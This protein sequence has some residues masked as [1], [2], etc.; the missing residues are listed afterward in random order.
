MRI[1]DG[2]RR[3]NFV[4]TLERRA[5]TDFADVESVVR[6]IVEDV[7]KNGDRSLRLYAARWDG[8]GKKEPLRVPEAE[9]QEAW[10][11]TPPQ[12]QSAIR[13]AAA[14][15][16][17]Y[18]EWQKPQEWQREIQPGVCVGQL[19]RPLESV[20]CY[21]PGGRYPLPST[22]LM[23]VIPAQVAGVRQIRVVSPKAAPVTLAVAGFLSV[24]EFYR[25]GG[26]QAIAALAYG[27]ESVAPVT[28]IVGPGNRFVTAAK[29]RVAFDCA[30]EFLAGPTEAVVISEDGDPSCIASDLVAQAE[31]DPDALCVFITPVCSLAKSV[32]SEVKIRTRNNS[33]ARQSLTRR[34]A[35]LL[36]ASL[37]E[38]IETASRIAPEHLTVPAAL[39][40]AVRNAGSVFLDEFSP[41]AAGDYI[42]GPNHVLPTGGMARV[43]GGLSVLDFVQIIACQNVSKE[44][45]QHIAPA[46]IA[47]AEA[48][49]LRGHAESLRVRCSHA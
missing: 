14:N 13:Q 11:Q 19:V 15:I 17:R 10:H 31:H 25:V 26:A 30:I 21:V 37:D 1:L 40:P 16:R 45:I 22:L 38:A 49:G 48:E 6:R 41:Q 2:P 9:L 34:G 32:Q 43:R 29:K 42:S 46:A 35:I 5:T 18:C 7:R 24:S 8:L 44:G 3:H 4:R 27:T 12:L 39:A 28:K 20:G 47:L 23:T 33:I 36:V